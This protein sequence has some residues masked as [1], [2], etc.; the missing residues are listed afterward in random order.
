MLQRVDPQ[1]ASTKNVPRDDSAARR[2][3]ESRAFASAAVL[4]GILL[5]PKGDERNDP[6]RLILTISF[7][8]TAIFGCCQFLEPYARY[9]GAKYRWAFRDAPPNVEKAWQVYTYSLSKLVTVFAS[10]AI[11][12]L[13]TTAV[14]VLAAW[15]ATEGIK[16]LEPIAQ[17][18][19]WIAILGLVLAPFVFGRQMREVV[20][21]RDQM[22]Q[23]AHASGVE[24]KDWREESRKDQDA[25]ELPP[26]QVADA[27]EFV[28]GGLLWSWEELTKNAAV[29]GGT[30][31]GKTVCVLNALLDGLLSSSSAAHL[32]A[33]GL[34]LDPKGDFRDKIEVL[35]TRLGREDDLLILDPEDPVRSVRWN[36]FENGGTPADDFES[37][38]Q[39]VAV[40]ESLGTKAGEDSFWIDSSRKFAQHALTLLRLANNG[41][42]PSFYGIYEL[43][44]TFEAVKE[45]A[46]TIMARNQVLVDF[47]CEEALKYFA[48][49][50]MT[51][52]D[53][54]R[55]S[56]QAQLGNL[57]NPFTLNPYREFFAG[58]ST[59]TIGEILDEGRVLYVNVPEARRP[60]MSR[61]I[62]TMVKQEFYRQVRLRVRKERGSFLLCD[63][64]QKFFTSAVG[65]GDADFFDISRDSFHVNVIGTQNL[66]GLQAVAQKKETVDKM[67]GV[68]LTKIFLRNT[69]RATNEFAA[70]QVGEDLL[71]VVGLGNQGGSFQR[72]EIVPPER[73]QA[74]RQPSRADGT[75]IAESVTIL[76]GR[77]TAGW[78]LLKWPVHPLTR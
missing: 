13:T 60:V 31:S 22:K 50:W 75:R 74:L 61:V 39:L 47:D 20:E 64:F 33:S 62:C 32:P 77:S 72:G 70:K 19:F 28:A 29:F 57:L 18:L 52:P 17:P 42:P 63:E 23:V 78:S 5:I 59:T 14:R 7:F 45:S 10:L 30:G 73:F 67:L 68:I 56:I 6:Y 11:L 25:E 37:A 54:T 49:E 55:S 48:N 51:L 46:S 24:A 26:V 12:V 38:G 71:G 65:Q 8:T 66:S 2:R 9:L 1:R 43:S 36:P 76:G 34:I 44:S 58:R 41:E 69:D 16:F 53:K 3:F 4:V 35:M 40:M 21:R 27:H 15:P